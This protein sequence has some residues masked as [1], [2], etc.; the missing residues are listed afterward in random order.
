MVSKWPP[1][2]IFISDGPPG[3]LSPLGGGVSVGVCSHQPGG[4][5]VFA[6]AHM[7]ACP[8]LSMFAPVGITQ[9]CVCPVT[10]S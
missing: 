7:W 4:I 1:A 8:Q 9:L 3:A 10:F 5:I 2:V 6:C